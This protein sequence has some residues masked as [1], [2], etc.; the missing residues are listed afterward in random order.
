V[1]IIISVLPAAW[2]MYSENRELVHREVGRR[3]GR[4][5]AAKAD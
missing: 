1:I 5:P 4:R 3:L 2:H